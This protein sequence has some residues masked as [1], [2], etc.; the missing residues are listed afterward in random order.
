MPNHV[1]QS[2]PKDNDEFWENGNE[3]LKF[4]VIYIYIIHIYIMMTR[5]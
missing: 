5:T 4:I 2:L 1:E 3:A